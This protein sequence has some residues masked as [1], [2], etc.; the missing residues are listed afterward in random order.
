MEV[1]TKE[2]SYIPER[3]EEDDE[4]ED[5]EEQGMT[6]SQPLLWRLSITIDYAKNVNVELDPIQWEDN[7][8]DEQI[9]DDFCAQLRKELKQ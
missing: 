1:E 2:N 3:L 8:D 6:L 9:D 4:F 7:W 5:F